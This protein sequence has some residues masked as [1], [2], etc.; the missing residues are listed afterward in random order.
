[1]NEHTFLEEM[2]ALPG[3]TEW[4]EMERQ[5]RELRKAHRVFEWDGWEEGLV[6]SCLGLDSETEID[7]KDHPPGMIPGMVGN[8][9]PANDAHPNGLGLDL[10]GEPVN[11][12]EGKI[13]HLDTEGDMCGGVGG[14]LGRRLEALVVNGFGS[15]SKGKDETLAETEDEGGSASEPE[16][17][18]EGPYYDAYTSSPEEGSNSSCE[19]E[20]GGAPDPGQVHFGFH[21]FHPSLSR[22]HS[23]I[24]PVRAR[25]TLVPMGFLPLNG[26]P[27]GEST[28]KSQSTPYPT[29]PG[30]RSPS[31][32]MR[33]TGPNGIPLSLRTNTSSFVTPSASTP[34]SSTPITPIYNGSTTRLHQLQHLYRDPRRI[35]PLAGPGDS[36]G[37]TAFSRGSPSSDAG[38]AGQ[39]HGNQGVPVN[40]AAQTKSRLAMFLAAN[41]VGS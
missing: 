13:K 8:V 32:V 1:M 3:G 4:I 38:V 18:E 28:P 35:A 36:H 34:N 10:V 29:Y 37:R 20:A 11:G 7:S 15:P 5:G 16:E 26:P 12:F 33:P 6:P 27:P 41:G 14:E 19:E 17:G 2:A 40:R 31:Q 24:H 9:G 21:N 22:T 23:H 30:P 39:T 25:T